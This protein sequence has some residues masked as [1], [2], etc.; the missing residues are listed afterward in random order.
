MF[1]LILS[2]IIIN[3]KL[4]GDII[5]NDFRNFA[6][7]CL[8][9]DILYLMYKSFLGYKIGISAHLVSCIVLCILGVAQSSIII[10]SGN[11]SYISDES[12]ELAIVLVV[13]NALYVL[14]KKRHYF[15][16]ITTS[17]EDRFK[18]KPHFVISDSP[19]WLDKV[20]RSKV[21]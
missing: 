17:L 11:G 21:I 6:I 10:N 20:L 18:R 2:V 15:S 4:N 16:K 5:T 13:F 14:Y 1:S 7:F 9:C 3:N 12:Y 8:L 19:D